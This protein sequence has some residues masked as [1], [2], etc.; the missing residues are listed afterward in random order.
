[1]NIQYVGIDYHT[2]FATATKMDRDG[3]ILGKGKIMNNKR[4]I[5]DYLSALPANSQVVLE[6][7]NNWYA[8]M[9]WSHDLPIDVKLAHPLKLKAIAQARIK[10]DTVDSKILAD[11]L[12]SNFIPE[13]YIAPK[14]IRDTRELIR[15][16]TTLV[17]IRTQFITRIHAVLFKVGEQI[18]ATD[19]TGK[20]EGRNLRNWISEKSTGRKLTAA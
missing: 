1:M 5:R 19:V 11:L 4:D 6:A 12:R 9:E 14:E 20:K 3:N 8:F 16:R 15:Y 18:T 10:T 2:K 13:S 17:R 7:T